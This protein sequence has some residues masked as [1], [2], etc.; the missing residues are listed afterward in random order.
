MGASWQLLASGQSGEENHA[1]S[2]STHIKNRRGQAL[3]ELSVIQA[4]I[5]QKMVWKNHKDMSQSTTCPENH[6]FPQRIHRYIKWHCDTKRIGQKGFDCIKEI[7]QKGCNFLEFAKT[8]CEMCC[9]GF[10][11][12]WVACT[13]RLGG[14][15][16]AMAADICP[17][18]TPPERELPGPQLATGK[19]TK[20]A[21]KPLIGRGGELWRLLTNQSRAL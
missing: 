5:S 20:L 13:E 18:L 17:C 9:Y 1:K 15:L 3:C 4:K 7:E 19:S 12:V 6:H 8:K 14:S 16:A 2:G 11:L 21:R 10:G